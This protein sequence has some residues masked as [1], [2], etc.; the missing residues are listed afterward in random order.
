[1]IPRLRADHD[2]IRARAHW[3]YRGRSR[4]EFAD[5]VK[6]G[7]TSVWDFSRPPI[8]VPVDNPLT[9]KLGGELIAYTE[10]GVAVKETAGAPTYYFP[11]EDVKVTL[12]ATSA[13]SLCEWKGMA[14]SLSVHGVE[15]AAWRYEEMF[16]EFESLYLWVAFYPALLECYVGGERATPQ[17]GG[18]YGGWVTSDLC[19]PIKGEPGSSGW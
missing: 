16:E 4:P 2:I 11:P 17:P 19:G 7:Q 12:S 14:R 5:Q 8:Q 1:M 9:V 10:R 13:R 18:Y 3:R 6:E 15:H